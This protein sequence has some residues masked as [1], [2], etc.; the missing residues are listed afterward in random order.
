MNRKKM[1]WLVIAECCLLLVLIGVGLGL[2]FRQEAV[3]TMADLTTAPTESA[4]VTTTVP[5]TAPTV[6]TTA[7]AT[8]PPTETTAETVPSETVYT[9][10][11]AGDC[12]LG[13]L[14]GYF[15]SASSF[16]GVVGENY[17][18]PFA[19]VQDWFANDDFT[20]V[21]LEGPLSYEGSPA[22]KTYV[23]QGHP[24][25]VNILT[26]GS[27]E[28]V[29]LAN[30]HTMDL[31]QHAYDTTRTVLQEAGVAFAG[32]WETTLVET[33][34]G[35]KV[36]VLCVS[37]YIEHEAMANRIAELKEQGA[38]VVIVSFHWGIEGTYHHTYDQTSYAYAA[39]DAGANIV[40]GHH[41][42][43]LQEMESYNGGM[44]Y[45]SLGNFAFGGNDCPRDFDTALI[46]QQVI[47]GIDGTVRL[48]ECTPV[49][50]AISSVT[51]TNDFQ[52][53]PAEP[54][55]SRYDRV[56]AKLDGSYSGGDLITYTQEGEP[57]ET[58][59][60]ETTAPET[61]LS[62]TEASTSTPDEDTHP[63]ENE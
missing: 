63:A 9:L 62:P 17:G 59:A 8:V 7:P 57:D 25:Y 23:M 29:S 38:Q 49:P 56:M 18:Y 41:P 20:M 15:G 43:V 5:T 2:Y 34:R 54:G 53:T 33:E 21:N 51:H 13:T 31:G 44:I 27:V 42:H 10:T 6:Q 35:L 24:K 3:Q 12:T 60:P 26:Q 36:G 22:D 19:A 55:S 48:G 30:N 40:F 32:D 58:A 11:F 28:C 16:P 52:P 47:V 39:I 61:T 4:T 46:S 50:C 1:L 14:Y 45:Y 37:F